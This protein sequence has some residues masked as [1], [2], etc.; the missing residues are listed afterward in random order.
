MNILV[1]A[2]LLGVKCRY[3]GRDNYCDS[4]E[5]L[6]EK[7]HLIPVCPESYG[8]LSI[9]R[10]PSEIQGD[11]VVSR[12]GEDVTS[13]FYRGAESLM[14]LSR[15]FDCKTAVLK[16]RSPSCGSGQ[17]YDGT[18]SKKL[19]EGNGIFAAMLKEEGV[20]VI[21]ESEIDLHFD[22]EGNRK[23]AGSKR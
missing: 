4:L 5:R 16:E 2:C 12:S 3:D 10:E 6:K 22:A 18:F 8:G 13:Q 9:P 11:R 20:N 15:Y 23:E 19:T 17:I 14:C 7:H 21:G 1:S